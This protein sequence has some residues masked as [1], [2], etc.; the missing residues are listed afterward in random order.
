MPVITVENPSAYKLGS[1]WKFPLRRKTLDPASPIDLTG[2]AIRAVFRTKSVTGPLLAELTEAN[3]GIA[4]DDV[5]GQI[6]MTVSAGISA[7]AP[8][9]NWVYFE[10]E[11]IS[12]SG[13]VWQS[14]TYRFRTEAQVT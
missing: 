2:L 10:V 11:M 4:R 1:T 7:L 8:A 5:N 6:I 12:A 9:D 14:P 3:D 13:D